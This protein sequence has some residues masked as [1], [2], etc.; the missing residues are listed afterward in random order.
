M[1]RVSDGRAMPPPGVF[2]DDTAAVTVTIDDG[3]GGVAPSLPRASSA[4]SAAAPAGGPPGAQ[5]KP[6][7]AATGDGAEVPLCRRGEWCK[8]KAFSL[9]D[10]LPSGLKGSVR[11]AVAVTTLLLIG[12]ST[13]PL[14]SN[15][16]DANTMCGVGG[17][18]REEDCA[19]STRLCYKHQTLLQHRVRGGGLEE[20]R[21][22]CP[23]HQTVLIPAYLPFPPHAA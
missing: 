11:V 16:D 20:G 13:Y 23:E 7:P 18:S 1:T 4:G 12:L 10:N 15:T 21:G 5:D 14:S 9:Y 8:A 2:E 22:L 3:S 6:G 19:P 17:W